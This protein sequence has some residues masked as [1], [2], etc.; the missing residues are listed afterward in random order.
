M[1]DTQK[2]ILLIAVL[3]LVAFIIGIFGR[4]WIDHKGFLAFGTGAI[5]ILTFF[6][7]LP[8]DITETRDQAQGEARVRRAIAIS[9]IVVY[10]VLVS[11][12]AFL[13]VPPELEGLLLNFTTTTGV[14]MA[15]YF[16]S[17]AYLEARRAS[18][19]ADAREK[20]LAR[21]AGV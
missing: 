18:R 4:V 13:D 2:R 17:S 8:L 6:G 11:T 15:F 16:G 12:F 21:S 10:L 5:A 7:I 19:P 20:E 3:D 1:T 14:V 9:V